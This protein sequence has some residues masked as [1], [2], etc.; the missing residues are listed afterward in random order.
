MRLDDEWLIDPAVAYLNHGGYGA[1][2]RQVADAAAAIRAEIEAD[3]TD[4]FMRRWPGWVA[5]VRAVVASFLRADEADLVF[6]ANATSGTATVLASF[7]FRAG[8]EIVTTDHRYPAVANQVG[9]LADR[10]V[11]VV[12]AAIPLEAPS[13]D[14][15]VDRIMAAVGSRT[16]LVVVDQIASPTGFVFPVARIVAACHDIG[17]PVLVDA[18]HAPGQLDLDLTAIDADFWVGNMHKWVCS[19]RGC[20]VMRVAPQ[21]QQRVRPLVPSHDYRGGFQPAFD[22]TGTFDAIPLLAIPAALRFW[23]GLGWDEVRRHQHALATDGAHAV[24]SRLGTS[25]AVREE[26]TAAMRLVELPRPVTADEGYAACERM[27]TEHK[28]TTYI[29]HHQGRSFVRLCGQL[30]NVPEHYERLA[31]ALQQTLRL[32][33]PP[34]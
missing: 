33:Q 16:K 25:V 21:W 34:G 31:T 27:T 28:V 3:P 30:Y 11:R 9:L 13:A 5:D 7:P 2:P 20:A 6:V 19:P 26:F 18:A 22:W 12:E 17:V 15:V 32:R 23:D 4:V 1:L 29:T 8:D 10:G 14:D 24:A